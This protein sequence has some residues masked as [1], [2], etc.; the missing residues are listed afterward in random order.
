[1][2][3]FFVAPENIN[4]S[5]VH[6]PMDLSHQI[7]R[8]L[9]LRDGDL[10]NVLDDQGNIF[11][12][13]I[14]ILESEVHG[15]ILSRQRSKA[16]PAV[17]LSLYIGLTQREKFEWILQKGT[18]IGVSRFVPFIS[19]RSLVQKTAAVEKKS[20]RWQKIIQEAAEQS[21]RGKIPVLDEAH[22][23]N[24]AVENAVDECQICLIP[25]E[26]T[27]QNS[28]KTALDGT[29]GG[30]SSIAVMIGPE[31]GFS[32]DEVH[33]ATIKGFQAITLGKRILRME[34]AAVAAAA[35]ILYHLGEME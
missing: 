35:M 2:H 15:E 28:L 19:E 29:A 33:F 26:E 17:S 8:V 20:Q 1:M 27:H 3:H 7:K 23:F 18:E 22:S 32:S 13:Q 25:W 5:Q 30:C 6:F 11:E 21:K 12:T 24:Q 14:K 16:E 34:T 4:A 31:G 9:R 10:V